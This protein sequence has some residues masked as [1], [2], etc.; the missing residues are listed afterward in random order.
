MLEVVRLRALK[1]NHR[2]I[3]G[4]SPLIPDQLTH[5]IL[6][7]AGLM[8]CL[9]NSVHPMQAQPYCRI[10][11]SRFLDTVTEAQH[12]AKLGFLRRSRDE[13]LKEACELLAQC[14]AE[15]DRLEEYY[16]AA[17][18]YQALDAYTKTISDQI[19]SS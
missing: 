18:D 8:L 11:A 13:I 5:L 7:D 2:I 10:N 16:K 15:H 6:P 9:S 1:A 4:Y 14:H 12:K 17:V 19:F 3:S